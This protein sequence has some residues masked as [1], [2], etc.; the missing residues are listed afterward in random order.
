V[1][2]AGLSAAAANQ[3]VFD[4]LVDLGLAEG[5]LTGRLLAG[6][7][8]GLLPPGVRRAWAGTFG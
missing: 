4:D 6:V 8:S 5:R 7:A 1:L 3:R 2:R